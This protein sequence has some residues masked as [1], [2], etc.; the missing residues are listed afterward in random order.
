MKQEF[1]TWQTELTALHE[2]EAPKTLAEQVEVGTSGLFSQKRQ[3]LDVIRREQPH[4]L[5]NN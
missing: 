5:Q 3:H 2:L 1:D 4:H